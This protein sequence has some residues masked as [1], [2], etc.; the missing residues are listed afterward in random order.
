MKV[1]DCMITTVYT[2]DVEARLREAM[3]LMAE[4]MIGTLPVIDT[5]RCLRGVLVMEDVL[6]RFMP[7][8]VEMIRSADFVHDYGV[9]AAGRQS[10]Q[11][12]EE[13]V[14]KLMR[15]AF[16]VTPDSGLMEALVVMHKHRVPD[17]PVVNGDEQ[18]IGLVSQARVG[19]L[20]LA[21]WLAHFPD[22]E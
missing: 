22:E 10:P 17:V 7:Q 5:D 11:L 13:P 12:A 4:P 14:K 2:V 19:S 18:V 1:A 21:D 9:F 20:F 6:T 3:R 8:F 15:S 16:Y